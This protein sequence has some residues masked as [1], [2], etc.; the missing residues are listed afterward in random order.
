MNIR[1][2]LKYVFAGCVA[3]LSNLVILFLLVN[4]FNIW[5]LISASISFCCAVIIS[6]LLQK[7]FVFKNNTKKDIYKQFLHL[8]S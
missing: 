7:Y 8:V 1:K 5:Y 4:F 6:Y 2:I 3:T